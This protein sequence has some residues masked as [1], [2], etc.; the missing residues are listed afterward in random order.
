MGPVPRND[1]GCIAGPKF[2]TGHCGLETGQY[3]EALGNICRTLLPLLLPNSV[4]WGGM[5]L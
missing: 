1:L 2:K 3:P 4:G 5:M